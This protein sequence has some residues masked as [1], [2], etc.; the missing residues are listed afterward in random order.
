ML[1]ESKSPTTGNTILKEM[2][3]QKNIIVEIVENLKQ[4]QF[5]IN[6]FNKKNNKKQALED[7]D[8]EQFNRK[9]GAS[10][11]P[12]N[13]AECRRKIAV[14]KKAILGIMSKIF[15]N[16]QQN[17]IPTMLK[18][19]KSR[20]FKSVIDKKIITNITILSNCITYFYECDKNISTKI[21]FGFVDRKLT[22]KSEEYNKKNPV[23]QINLAENEN[24]VL[25]LNITKNLRKITQKANYPDIQNWQK[26]DHISALTSGSNYND[27]TIND[28]LSCHDL[29]ALCDH[30]LDYVLFP[31]GKNA[32]YV[33][34]H[35]QGI[36]FTLLNNYINTIRCKDKIKHPKRIIAAKNFLYLIGE[37][38]KKDINDII[39]K[40]NS[41]NE[42]FIKNP[43]T[44]LKLLTEFQE[45]VKEAETRCSQAILVCGNIDALWHE[46][47]V[48]TK[49]HS[50]N[51][52]STKKDKL[53]P[54]VKKSNKPPLNSETKKILKGLK[55]DDA[56][57]E[58]IEK[59]I[60]GIRLKNLSDKEIEKFIKGI[61]LKNL[62]DKD[63]EK[64]I[65]DFK[66]DAEGKKK[67]E[68][69]VK[70]FKLDTES[71]KKIEAVV[72]GLKLNTSRE[73]KIEKVVKFFNLDTASIERI[74][75]MIGLRNVHEHHHTDRRPYA[76]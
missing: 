56:T 32:I 53:L 41:V 74:R 63:I 11:N 62:D 42:N 65:K 43:N 67:I 31:S 34:Q 28:L 35:F 48:I 44:S 75:E 2:Q 20:S 47:N 73:K 13:L 49:A 46:L 3:N 70:S 9:E 18:D 68:E 21:S 64:F 36:Y 1:K 30:N 6:Q 54:A 14:D 72:K 16:I 59:F 26:E 45:C 66:F 27:N 5:D 22:V 39:I 8:F 33:F 23:Q 4:I 38:L 61:R 29:D 71:K 37:D 55:L 25:L 51:K 10:L 17:I 57:L 7:R 24:L 19:K 76:I 50:S 60:K 12:K 69:V 52:P 58:N 40:I 15:Q